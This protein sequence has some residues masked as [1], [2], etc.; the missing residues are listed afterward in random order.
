LD[1]ISCKEIEK[2]AFMHG[3]ERMFLLTKWKTAVI[4]RLQGTWK[5]IYH[6]LFSSKG[7]FG[8]DKPEPEKKT[9]LFQAWSRE[10]GGI[11]PRGYFL[12]V[13]SYLFAIALL[14]VILISKQGKISFLDLPGQFELPGQL[15][16]K[17]ESDLPAEEAGRAAAEEASPGVS[18]SSAEGNNK[19]DLTAVPTLPVEEGSRTPEETEESGAGTEPGANTGTGGDASEGDL[20]AEAAELL[21][22]AVSPVSEW[23]LCQNFGEYTSE[24]LPSGGKLHSLARGISL[25]V[26]PGTPVAA[27]WDGRV[28][29][30]GGGGS[31][32][33]QYVILEHAGGYAT[34][35]GNLREVWVQEGSRV[36]RGE[37]LGLLPQFP[38]D[39]SAPAAAVPASQEKSGEVLLKTIWKGIP[40][41][42]DVSPSWPYYEGNPLLYLEVRQ[43]NN[44]LDPLPFIGARN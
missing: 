3:G 44:Y 43:G 39:E 24:K 16:S 35:Y 21:P 18:T 15:E 23:Q 30:I 4:R 2:F 19:K 9:S 40:G 5:G 13:G 33:S 34:F 41:D 36:Y 6:F 8:E 42:V 37:H 14:L 22:Q 10:L 11:F 1:I 32:Y 28:S 17:I 12:L 38:P 27:L 29:K 26:T 31:P 7:D 20:P 25:A